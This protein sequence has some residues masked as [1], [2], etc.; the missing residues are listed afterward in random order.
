MIHFL[1]CV[2]KWPQHYFIYWA[3][4]DARAAEWVLGQP[5][6][7]CYVTIGCQLFCD[8]IVRRVLEAQATITIWNGQVPRDAPRNQLQAIYK[9]KGKKPW[10]D[11]ADLPKPFDWKVH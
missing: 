3:V 8:N 4:E 7:Y 9:Q 10:L 5:V 2:L 6:G 1:A 11:W